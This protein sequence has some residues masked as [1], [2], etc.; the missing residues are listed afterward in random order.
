MEV[1]WLWVTSHGVWCVLS[2][3]SHWH[4][5]YEGAEWYICHVLQ[6]VTEYVM[7]LRFEP[8]FSHSSA[9]NSMTV[10]ELES[11]S[12]AILEV[13][14]QHNINLLVYWEAMSDLLTYVLSGSASLLEWSWLIKHRKAKEKWVFPS[15]FFLYLWLIYICNI[16][17]PYLCLFFVFVFFF[18]SATL[19]ML[20]HSDSDLV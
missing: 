5:H 15:F 19:C 18:P 14:L 8:F 9:F 4:R 12:L 17:K 7:L 10:F 6:A 11:F 13:N 3:K 1:L 20:S 16:F 2:G